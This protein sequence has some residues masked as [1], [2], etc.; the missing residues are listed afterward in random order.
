VSRVRPALPWL[1]VLVASIAFRLPSLINAAGTNSDAAVVGLQAMHVL[2][3]EWS[4]F[5]WGSGYQTSVDAVVAALVFL[6]TGPSPVALMLSTLGGHVLLTWMVFAML[7]R[8]L[9]P[10]TAAALCAVLVFTPDPVHTYVLY[11]P[12]Q[13]SLTLDFLGLFLLARASRWGGSAGGP[14]QRSLRARSPSSRP[15]KPP[16]ALTRATASPRPRVLLALGAAVT[17]FAVYADP[18][19][20]LFLPVAG[21]LGILGLRDVRS[22]RPELGRR[23]GALIGGFVAGMVPYQ[24][25][26]RHPLASR[27]QTSLRLEVIP[28]NLEL[29]WRDCL[30]W[31]LSTKVYAAKHMTDYQPWET[32]AAYH[33][34]QVVAA[35]VLVAGVASGGALFFVK[36]IPWEIRRLGLT[37]ALMLPVTLGGFLLS[38]M[39]MDHFSSRYLA[40][41][42]LMAPLALAPAAH[43]L[44]LR[45]LLPALCPY[46]LSAAVSGWVSYRPFG[47]ALH[48]SLEI[49]ERLGAALR[50]RGIRYAV[51]DYWA[52][53]RL[54]YMFR[55]NPVVVPKN[56]GEDRYKPYRERFEAEP[57]IAYVFDAYRSR[58][59]L[60]ETE[61]RFKNGET[62]FEPVYERFELG[63][64]TVFVLKRRPVER[65]AAR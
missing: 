23:L 62:M 46:L 65:M 55:E 34:F 56:E 16:G 5:L 33:G 21:L 32:G 28:H 29:L 47:L 2:R 10:W 30:P 8:V 26:M 60:G 45:S 15:P 41:I 51:A 48:P 57:V 43:L 7:R 17:S 54:T 18:Y 22:D 14:P 37:G 58:E 64:F 39:V 25:L 53:Y 52:S 11:P 20:L 44:P 24:L 3:G 42:L 36:K 35:V 9:P 31:L 61:K 49:D 13:A 12:R 6:I 63:N 4:P 38:P 50:E 1:S 59:N 40:A 19:G 27:G